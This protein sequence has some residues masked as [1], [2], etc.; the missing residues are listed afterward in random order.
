M[1]KEVIILEVGMG[2]TE[3]VGSD[4]YP[5]TIHRIEGKK[6]WVSQD[7]AVATN[8]SDFHGKQEYTYSNNNEKNPEAWKLCT[9]KKDG[10]WHFGTTLKGGRIYPGFR[11]Y[12]QDPSF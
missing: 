7:E 5:Y 8:N 9:L 12:Y 10:F 2:A 1:N 6:M 11:R 3:G 4:S